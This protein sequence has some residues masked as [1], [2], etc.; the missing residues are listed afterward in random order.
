[1]LVK[2]PAETIKYRYSVDGHLA[3]QPAMQSSRES[4]SKWVEVS[5]KKKKTLDS[6]KSKLGF[7][8]G[9]EFKMFC[10]LGVLIFLEK[11]VG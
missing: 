8:G 6:I 4:P 9:K 3:W 2:Y 11:Q 1:M 10:R 5:N 7:P